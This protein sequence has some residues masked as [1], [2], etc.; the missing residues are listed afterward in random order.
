M[1]TEEEKKLAHDMDLEPEVVFNTIS[2]LTVWSVQSEET[3]ESLF[4]IS[5]YGLQVKFDRSKLGDLADVEGLLD[6]IKDLFRK[7]IVQD[8]LAPSK[9]NS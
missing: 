2:D 5:G 9:P 1:V 7:L 4:E 3:K 6:G 8:L